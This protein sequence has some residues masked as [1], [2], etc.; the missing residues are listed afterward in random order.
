MQ[1]TIAHKHAVQH[2]GTLHHH[3]IGED[4]LISSLKSQDCT[5]T[6]NF[7]PIENNCVVN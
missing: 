2:I 7:M 5:P 3:T 6:V 4:E 1:A